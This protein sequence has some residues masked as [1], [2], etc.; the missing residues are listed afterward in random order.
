MPSQVITNNLLLIKILEL[1]EEQKK[2]IEILKA[3]IKEKVPE[4]EPIS[5][6]WFS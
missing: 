5:T 6:G 1:L 2:E 4:P 3:Y